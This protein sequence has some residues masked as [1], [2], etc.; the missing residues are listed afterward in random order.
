[1]RPSLP[2]LLASTLLLAPLVGFA[3]PLLLTP[4]TSTV[5][6]AVD[7]S[8]T[9]EV[10]ATGTP[11]PTFQWQRN[12]GSG[13]NDLVNDTAHSGVTTAR[14]TVLSPS[15]GQDNHQYRALI[16]NAG[17]TVTSYAATLRVFA[18]PTQTASLT[19]SPATLSSSATSP[20]TL[21]I[22][23]VPSGSTVR[24]QR[25]LDLDADGVIDPTDPAVLDVDI[26]DGQ[27]ASF[28]GIAIPNIPGDE[29]LTA[30][31]A[32]TTR[33]TL[34]RSSEIGRV[35]AGYL[36]R[37]SSSSG[38]FAPIVQPFAITNPTTTTLVSGVTRSGGVAV[39]HAVV[40]LL[41][42][43]ENAQFLN[44][45]VS[46]AAGNYTLYAPASGPYNFLAF[47]S[48]FVSAF[49]SA[50]LVTGVPAAS[51]I[52]LVAATRTLSGRVTSAANGAPLRAQQMFAQSD[53]GI[54]LVFTDP[55]GNF[56]FGVTARQWGVD[57]S[58]LTLGQVGHLVDNESRVV[59][60]TT[61]SQT[62]NFA[63]TRA[64]ALI[65]GRLLNGVTPLVNYEMFANLDGGSGLRSNALTD[66]DGR[67]YLP[68][69]GAA[70]APGQNW[71]AGATDNNDFSSFIPPSP[72]SV[73][74]LA[75]QAVEVNLSAI[76][77]NAVIRGRVTKDG[78]PLANVGLGAS[79][80]PPIPGVPSYIGTRTDIN[81]D[82]T[83]PL[84]AGT[85]NI[86]LDA[87]SISAHH[88]VAPSLTRTVAENE[89]LTGVN[90]AGLSGTSTISGLV[91][92]SDLQPIPN[93]GIFAQATIGGV[94]YSASSMT[95]GLGSYSL[96]VVA[97]NWTIFVDAFYGPGQFSANAV[98]T[99][100]D[101]TLNLT[102]SIIRSISPITL[103]GNVGQS[104]TLTAT[105]QSPGAYSAVWQTSLDGT[106]WTNLPDTA[107]YSGV[108]GLTLTIN[109]V[110]LTLTGRLY[111][112]QAI[113]NGN[114]FYSDTRSLTINTIPSIDA[115]RVANFTAPQLRNPAISGLAAAPAGDGLNNL[116]KYAFNLNPFTPSVSPTSAVSV[117]GAA[118]SLTFQAIRPELI[119][120][121]E[122]ST[123]L[124]NWTTSGV[125]TQTVGTTRTA[126]YT[127]PSGN[128]AFL[129][130]VVIEP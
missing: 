40:A 3:Q 5:A 35:A 45:A 56:S 65:Y 77:V 105:I 42:G 101:V 121:V 46:D 62:T 25:F 89:T 113:Y 39:P 91:R 99:T 75:G 64:T 28:S 100:A 52:S 14:V 71:S 130:I 53:D 49:G 32:I 117:S 15:L 59:D 107:P 44:G 126:R 58:E 92:D 74:L 51:D 109:P 84:V 123:N 72:A 83:L 128:R 55:D 21:S 34:Q 6:F 108:S 57:V 94:T 29:D 37:L 33:F 36:V 103:V 82:Y 38:A 116:A 114:P 9:F 86:Q 120:R 18:A 69:T 122:A 97:G 7:P 43:G 50:D 112:L 27:V 63:Q 76:A 20:V 118:V 11:T 54:A 80:N 79:P 85:W 4:P 81:G 19:V 16:T 1:M 2:L 12:T 23:G 48:G 95:N 106:E 73:V 66:S 31:G 119:Y 68:V 127:P 47:K 30:N 129:R 124:Q 67:F 111:R 17:G 125:T 13:W 87:E 90:L 96:P 115:W 41:G 93:T 88:L 8:A 10:V 78:V 110:D 61:T 60:T 24:V 104:T 22:G 70:I 26:T 102:R 98:V